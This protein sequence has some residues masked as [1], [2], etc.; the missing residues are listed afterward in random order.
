MR[1]VLANWAKIWHGAVKGGGVNGYCQALGLEL[2]KRGHEVVSF[3][4]GT[5]PGPSKADAPD[6]PRMFVRRHP[7]WRGISVYEVVGSPVRAPSRRQFPRPGP[8]TS[9]PRLEALVRDFLAAL[10]PDVIHF[11][12]LEGFSAGCVEAAAASGANV[13]FS[14][15]NYHPICPQVYLMQ[16]K[17]IACTNYDNGHCCVGC[18]TRFDPP[19][20]E[21]A[22][23]D[24]VVV[25]DPAL[26]N[27]PMP[28]PER[29][30]RTLGLPVVD[31]SVF[32]QTDPF[33]RPVLN[34][35]TAEPSSDKPPNAYARRR[36]AMVAALNQCDRV[37][38]VST[39]VTEK[40]EA[41]GVDR[42]RL[43]TMPIGTRMV[44]LAERLRRA[45]EPPAPFDDAATRLVRLV[46]LGFHNA[47][48]GLDLLA[49]SLQLLPAETLG[50][51]H[52]CIHALGGESIEPRF[53][54]LE[55][56]L[57]RLTWTPGYRYEDIPWL[58]GGA[59]IGIVPSVWWDNAPQTVF[60]FLACRV[61][62]LGAELGGIPDFVKHGVN[63]L[64]FRGNDR[65]DLARKLESIITHPAMLTRLRANIKPPKS[66]TAHVR[67]L[68]SLYK[69]VRLARAG[70]GGV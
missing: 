62:V 23:V 56:R 28:G 49:D 18:L 14:L 20:P 53:R 66:M 4:S 67:E 45:I 3:C 8:E 63:G 17:R 42:R 16:G 33:L 35:P 11:H 12:S 59:D 47:Y 43:L 24:P 40:F 48:K 54:R 44:E 19:A 1:I 9:A 15:H 58:V 65:H 32:D 26:I 31:E 46:F 69:V 51:F 70:R 13:L 38:G 10:S 37:L 21:E 22:P 30:P 50:R 36:A 2:V 68:E 25:D 57:G 5:S 55:A 34:I 7:D 61:P 27:S 60:E 52:L 39:F 41:M 6:G 29:D 64:L